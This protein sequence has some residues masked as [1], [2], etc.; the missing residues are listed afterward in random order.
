MK[1]IVSFICIVL[2]VVS[3]AQ[4]SIKPSIELG[5]R[6]Q[7]YTGFY[8]VN[9]ITA[10][11]RL[12]KSNKKSPLSVGVN[13]T[14]SRLGSAFLSNALSVNHYD[15]FFAY[16]FRS[17]K[18]LSPTVRINAGYEHTNLGDY[19]EGLVNKAFIMGLE[20]GVS[21]KLPY[22]LRAIATGGY[23]FLVV[24]NAAS[25]GSSVYPV[26]GQISL[27]YDLRRKNN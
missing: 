3:L 18:K 27:V 5:I 25:L 15:A 9:G 13:M 24:Q 21:F 17:S 4:D 16:Y 26:F 23:N 14:F 22:N 6:S 20:A 10:E 7:K 12:V 1:I 2:S 11:Y 19:F 8:I